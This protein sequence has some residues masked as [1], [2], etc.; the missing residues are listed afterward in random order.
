MAAFVVAVVAG[1][2]A[3]NPPGTVLGRALLAMLAGQ[4]GGTIV[5]MIFERLLAK[6]LGEYQRAARET[7]KATAEPVIEVGEAGE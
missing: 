5:G 7:A 2:G 6:H 1:L 3:D 4:T